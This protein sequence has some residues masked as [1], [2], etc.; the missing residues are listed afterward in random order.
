MG[1]NFFFWQAHKL[2]LIPSASALYCRVIGLCC[3]VSCNF[4]F[5]HSP[6]A[7]PQCPWM[8]CQPLSGPKLVIHLTRKEALPGRTPGDFGA[9]FLSLVSGQFHGAASTD[10]F[11]GHWALSSMLCS[12][13]LLEA[14]VLILCPQSCPCFLFSRPLSSADVSPAASLP[15]SS[16]MTPSP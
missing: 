16:L 10:S 13:S 9:V 11:R 15:S 1:A 2:S 12:E 7:A 8:S 14:L 6:L 3:P 4:S 5:P